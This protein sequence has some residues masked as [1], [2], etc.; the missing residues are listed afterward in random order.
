MKLD[1]KYAHELLMEAEKV[2]PG[3]YVKH[4]LT[5][6]EAAYRIASRLNLDADKARA[7]GY[8]HDIGKIYG[9]PFDQH[10]ARGYEFLIDKGIDE[11]YANICLVHSY[12]ENDIDC[13]A[14]TV[15]PSSYGYQFRKDFIKNHEYTIYEKIICLCDLTCKDEFLTLEERLI[16]LAV[17]K[18]IN[19]N[20]ERHIKA[21]IKLKEKIEILIG[22]QLYSLF[23]EIADRLIQSSNKAFV[24]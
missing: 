17:R 7:L 20:T 5:V 6:G 10:I 21:A 19:K 14:G 24:K 8:I 13:T 22:A 15:D 11:E 16:D 3:G 1:S 2:S 4:S 12:L 23:P 18:G 9:A